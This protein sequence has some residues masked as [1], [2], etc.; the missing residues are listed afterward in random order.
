MAEGRP[1]NDGSEGMEGYCM[2]L[3]HGRLVRAEGL[4]RTAAYI[5]I[6]NI[7]LF[8]KRIYWGFGKNEEN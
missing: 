3:A 4:H 6:S 5:N 7:F 8:C 2:A 1:G